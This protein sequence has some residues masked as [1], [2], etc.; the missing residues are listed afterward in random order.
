MCIHPRLGLS[1]DMRRQPHRTS[2]VMEGV[3]PARALNLRGLGDEVG[4]VAGPQLGRASSMPLKPGRLRQI[5]I[6]GRDAA[7]ARPSGG[8]H[9]GD[10]IRG[11][12][13]LTMVS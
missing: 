8:S 5:G 9:L 12:F 3:C 11:M 10:P 13:P 1:G 2:R 7:P 4:A 6:G